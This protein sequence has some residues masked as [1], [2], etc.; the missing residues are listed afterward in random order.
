[1]CKILLL[2]QYDARG[3]VPA[4]VAEAGAAA[5]AN[6]A[7]LRV[8]PID[9]A[10]ARDV[11][12]A[13]AMAIGIDGRDEA[14]PADTKHWLDALGFSGW[15]HLQRK[16]GC[17][18]ATLARGGDAAAACRMVARILRSRGMEAV[19]PI[20]L[21]VAEPAHAHDGAPLGAAFARWCRQPQGGAPSPRWKAG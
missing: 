19:T 15:R 20:E 4:V 9:S 11:A 3:R 6:G 8:R 12:W 17:V 14:L 2:F 5:E 21:D 10:G 16:P 13:D 18:F 7:D 1:M